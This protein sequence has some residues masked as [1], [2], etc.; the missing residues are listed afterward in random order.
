MKKIALFLALVM[1]F[2]MSAAALEQTESLGGASEGAVAIDA[3]LT[4]TETKKVYYFDQN[5]EE[6]TA[7]DTYL[8]TQNIN[9]V[10]SSG[11][12]AVDGVTVSL[13]KIAGMDD[14]AARVM[15]ENGN[16]YLYFTNS[17]SYNSF[18]FHFSDNTAR[19]F[20]VSFDYKYSEHSWGWAKSVYPA[21]ETK[22]GYSWSPATPLF[23]VVQ[24][25]WTHVELNVA[26]TWAYGFASNNS[27]MY[28]AIDNI[29]VWVEE[30]VQVPSDNKTFYFDQDFEELTANDTYLDTQN[31]NT[32]VSS[33][34]DAVDGVTVSLG[35][36]AGMDDFAARVMEENGN[37]YLYFTNS[38]S[39]NSFGFHFSDN[40]ARN[41][42]VSFDYKYSEHSWGWAKSVYPAWETKSGYSWSPATPLFD[43][44]QDTWTHVELNVA[45]T[46]AYGFA[47]NNSPVYIAIDNIKVWVEETEK[48]DITFAN[49]TS[50]APASVTL[51]DSQKVEKGDTAISLSDFTATDNNKKFLFKGWSTEAD[52]SNIVTS[53]TPTADTTLYAVWKINFTSAS[54]Q[55]RFDG[56]PGIRMMFRLR[57]ELAEAADAY[58]FIAT[59]QSVLTAKEKT[60]DDLTVDSTF[61]IVGYAKGGSLAEGV[62]KI[63]MRDEQN[64]RIITAVITGIPETKKGYT[65][66]FFA[67]PFVQIG[68]TTYLGTAA[69]YSYYEVA[70]YYMTYEKENLTQDQ[71]T[72]AQKIIDV[73]TA[74]EQ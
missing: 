64:Q 2:A 22:S 60:I 33:G 37:K 43:V 3:A 24:D 71:Q 69:N 12:D 19:N 53:I 40:T 1:T 51:P 30:E 41:F 52:G 72:F 48:V 38:S 50:N 47:S 65:E 28:I 68:E 27:P 7:N 36:I 31:I 29:K 55:I 49:S 6:L 59:A 23:D 32:V 5:F 62:E 13:G 16:K 44:V 70:N 21:W 63:F 20:K 26:D 25:T 45:D 54:V 67:K 9:T 14:F 34:V 4:E 39:Y 15:E 66:K 11:V 46:W 57:N 10:V 74:T 17:S 8:D 42:K 56:I 58:G 73:A 35:K 18:G 61:G